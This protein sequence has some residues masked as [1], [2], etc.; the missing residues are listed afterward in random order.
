MLKNLFKKKKVA[1]DFPIKKTDKEWKEKLSDLEYSVT[2]Q[3]STEPPFSGDYVN[4][5][6]KGIYNCRCCEAPLFDYSAK[7]N[8]HTGWPSFN[9]PII[10]GAVAS[11]DDYSLIAKRTEVLCANCGAHLGHV[12]SDGPKSTGLRYCINSVSLL[13][14]KQD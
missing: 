8:S 9:T 13:F 12:F 1:K 2:R 4:L 11:E 5:N 7:F 10:E 14:K 6:D 3:K